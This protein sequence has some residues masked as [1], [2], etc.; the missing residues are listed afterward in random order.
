MSTCI[1]IHIYILLGTQICINKSSIESLGIKV[2]S[3]LNFAASK[4][5]LWHPISSE[6]QCY[7]W[8]NDK[9]FYFKQE[10][11]ENLCQILIFQSR[12]RDSISRFVG[13]LVGPTFGRC[14]RSTRLMAIGLVLYKVTRKSDGKQHS[15]QHFS[16]HIPLLWV[17]GTKITQFF[18]D[19]C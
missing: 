2:I 11:L 4:K 19:R 15:G 16:C 9:S 1:S 3:V 6:K 17:N 7:H 8:Q 10:V 13:P 18:V 12:A 5:S 14:S